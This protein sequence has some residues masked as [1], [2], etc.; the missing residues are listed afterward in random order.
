M[1]TPGRTQDQPRV[2]SGV[3]GAGQYAAVMR[4]EPEDIDLGNVTFWDP[5]EGSFE[6]PPVPKTAKDLVRFWSSV[7]L[8]KGAVARF[9]AAYQERRLKELDAGADEFIRD[10]PEPVS[11]FKAK[12]D[13]P[14][15][16]EW[17]ERL[18]ASGEEYDRLN[19]IEVTTVLAP[20][21]VRATKMWQYSGYVKDEGERELIAKVVIELPGG[22]RLSLAEIVGRYRSHELVDFMSDPDL[23]TPQLLH[24]IN[25]GIK[26]VEDALYDPGT[27]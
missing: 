6:F 22:E 21:I 13:N 25:V 14:K 17:N 7:E 24:E 27:P 18:G 23:Q 16:Q 4:P 15:W 1:T 11:L 26:S 9:R 5:M 3:P 20:S 8:P 19:P 10:N 12:E 2:L